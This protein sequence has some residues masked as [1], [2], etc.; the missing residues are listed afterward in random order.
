MGIVFST[1]VALA[2]ALVCNWLMRR[3]AIVVALR[4]TRGSLETTLGWGQLRLYRRR[5]LLDGCR[6]GLSLTVERR[7]APFRPS[8]SPFDKRYVGVENLSWGHG[9]NSDTGTRYWLASVPLWFALA[10][11]F[12]ILGLFISI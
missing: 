11:L 10:A 5:G 3:T 6:N 9:Q 12:A 7:W 8:R 1:S 2:A 4:R